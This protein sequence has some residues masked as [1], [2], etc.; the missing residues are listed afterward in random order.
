[1]HHTVALNEPEHRPL[2]LE[3]FPNWADRIEYWQVCDADVMPASVALAAIDQQI[4]ALLSRI[5]GDSPAGA[6][7]PPALPPH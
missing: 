7:R 4:E 3:R 2:M 1:M 6:D 5:G